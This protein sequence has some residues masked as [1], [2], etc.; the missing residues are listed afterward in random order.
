VIVPAALLERAGRGA[1]NIHPGPPAYP[2]THPCAFAAY[3]GTTRFGATL[4]EMAARVDS[5]AI[6]DVERIDVPP[7]AG[8]GTYGAAARAAVAGL[9]DRWLVRLAADPAPLPPAGLGWG[10]RKS[11]HRQ[12]LAMRRVEPGI[13]AEEFARRRRAFADSAGDRLVL[14]LHGREFVFTRP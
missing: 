13:A 6:V 2:G 3:D 12:L 11:T 1:Y 4:H 5:G 10:P 8:V 9:L 14:D 7:E